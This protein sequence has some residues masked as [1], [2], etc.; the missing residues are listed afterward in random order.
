MEKMKTLKSRPAFALQEIKEPELF[1]DQFPYSEIP[2]IKFNNQFTPIA[3]AENIWIT[4]TTF[5][6]GQQARP[7]YT[8]DQILHLFDLLHKLGG[9]TGIIRQ[10]EFFLYSKRD[11]EA[12]EKCLSRK[13]MEVSKGEL[14]RTILAFSLLYGSRILIMDEPIFAL[15]AYQ[16]E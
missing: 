2:K 1:R 5:R 12:L 8:P 3:P 13:T 10:S 11:Q 4:D 15:E 9:K 14:Q 6:D 16:K 7:P